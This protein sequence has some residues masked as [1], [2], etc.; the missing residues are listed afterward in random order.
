VK[1]LLSLQTLTPF[2]MLGVLA[3]RPCGG[4]YA[5]SHA[6]ARTRAISAAR[7]RLAPL[8]TAAPA[9]TSSLSPADAA[10]ARHFANTYS[11]E[12][13]VTPGRGRGLLTPRAVVEG[14][15]LLAEPR[16][17]LAVLD[18]A[19]APRTCAHCFRALPG[20]NVAAASGIRDSSSVGGVACRGGCGARR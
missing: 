17:L 18:L 10:L 19:G 3:H 11:L 14:E 12:L 13:R 5:A 2:A 7:A 20:S 16:P 8:S 9:A 1:I 6:I 15:I 4:A